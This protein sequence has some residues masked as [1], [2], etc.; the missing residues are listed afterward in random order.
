[1][2]QALVQTHE[3]QFEKQWALQPLEGYMQNKMRGIVG[4]EIPITRL[5]GKY[6]MSQNRSENDQ[7]RVISALE[8]KGDPV[9]ADV[10]ALMSKRRRD[11]LG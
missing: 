3:A 10:A 7:L 4:F 2:L 8:G 1:M 6:K 9:S 11:G 5:E